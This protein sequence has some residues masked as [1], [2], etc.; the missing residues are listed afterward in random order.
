MARLTARRERPV[1]RLAAHISARILAV[2][3]PFRIAIALARLD[4][5]SM[6]HAEEPAAVPLCARD[7]E[8]DGGQARIGR[9]VPGEPFVDDGHAF[10]PVLTLSDQ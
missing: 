9:A 10:D 3:A 4:A 7:G 2:I 8:G 5:I 6:P 1:V